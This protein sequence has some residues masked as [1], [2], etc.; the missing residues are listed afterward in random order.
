VWFEYLGLN[1]DL[2]ININT[3]KS[4]YIYAKSEKKAELKLLKTFNHIIIV[5]R[6]E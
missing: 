3:V 2:N 5:R 4:G 6:C 1:G